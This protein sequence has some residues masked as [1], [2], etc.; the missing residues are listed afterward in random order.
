VP[1]ILA[2]EKAGGL[3]LVR[4]EEKKKE[5]EEEGALCDVAP[6]VLDL[7][8]SSCSCLHSADGC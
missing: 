4:D 5:G 1:L 6:T 8:V 7:M 2:G 3:A